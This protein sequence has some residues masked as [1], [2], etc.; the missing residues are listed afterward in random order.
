MNYINTTIVDA[1]IKKANA[2]CPDSLELIGVYGSV[3][4]LCPKFGLSGY[5][6]CNE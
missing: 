2:L 6:A 4:T 3:K 1:V 5:K